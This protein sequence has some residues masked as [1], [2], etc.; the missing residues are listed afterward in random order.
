MDMCI[1]ISTSGCSEL[2]ET[3]STEQ[4]KASADIRHCARPFTTTCIIS[5]SNSRARPQ[6]VGKL[7]GLTEK[8][9]TDRIELGAFSGK[10]PTLRPRTSPELQYESRVSKYG[11]I[12]V[13]ITT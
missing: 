2:C 8:V 12:S 1:N 10:K 7:F 4:G 6:S 9:S 13:H 3:G 11:S 5:K